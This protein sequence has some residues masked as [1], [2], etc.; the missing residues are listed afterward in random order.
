[1][2]GKIFNSNKEKYAA[3]VKAAAKKFK[4]YSD[5]S[6]EDMDYYITQCPDVNNNN[7]DKQ[8]HNVYEFVI[9]GLGIPKKKWK[10]LTKH[11]V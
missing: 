6:L 2:S 8:I 7:I 1:M 5:Y 10:K 3:K 11:T 9:A 4:D